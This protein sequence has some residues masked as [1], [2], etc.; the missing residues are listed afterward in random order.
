MGMALPVIV[1]KCGGAY[2][3]AGTAAI[4]FKPHD[5]LDSA[6]KIYAFLQDPSYITGSQQ[7]V[8][9]VLN[10]SVGLKR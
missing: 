9:S 4:D 1:P 5:P 8:W 7:K 3:V 10:F 2:E 6:E